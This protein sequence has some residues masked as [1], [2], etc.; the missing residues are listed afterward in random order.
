MELLGVFRRG[1]IPRPPECL[2]IG[3]RQLVASHNEPDLPVAEQ[4]AGHPVADAVNI[5]QLA[6]LRQA[7]DGGDI[8]IRR[9]GPVAGRK[10]VVGFPVP[11]HVVMGAKLFIKPHLIQRDGTAEA[12]RHAVHGSVEI[13]R[14]LCGSLKGAD[15]KPA[16]FQIFLYSGKVGHGMLSLSS[17]L[18][19]PVFSM[20]SALSEL[21]TAG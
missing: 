19:S 3:R 14:R 9:H 15:L 8:H 6:G 13:I 7:V 16:G 12:Y 18:Y 2:L 17:F 5:D 11:D 21:V 10:L 1:N 20:A 4:R